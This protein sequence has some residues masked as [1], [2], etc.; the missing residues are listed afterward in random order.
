MLETLLRSLTGTETP[1]VRLA[2]AAAPGA[3]AASPSEDFASNAFAAGLPFALSGAVAS[4]LVRRLARETREV[5]E[6][7]PC[8]RTPER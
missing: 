7:A 1:R 5:C 8:G 4:W 2:G 3:S 6:P